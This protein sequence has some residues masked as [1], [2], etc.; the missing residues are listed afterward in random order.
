MALTGV[1]T[2]A[3]RSAAAVDGTA[4]LLAAART[5]LPLRLHLAP[6]AAGTGD[7]STA[8]F[9]NG[10]NADSPAS[11]GSTATTVGCQRR[12]RAVPLPLRLH[13]AAAAAAAGIGK[14]R[15]ATMPL[16]CKKEGMAFDSPVSSLHDTVVP[17]E[18]V[19]DPS[20]PPLGF[21]G[22]LRLF[23]KKH[24]LNS[25]VLSI[26]IFVGFLAFKQDKKATVVVTVCDK[27]HKVYNILIKITPIALDLIWTFCGCSVFFRG[28]SQQIRS[29]GLAEARGAMASLVSISSSGAGAAALVCT[30]PRPRFSTPPAHA[31]LIHPPCSART[32]PLRLPGTAVAARTAAAA[33]RRLS[34]TA[35]HAASGTSQGAAAADEV[36]PPWGPSKEEL[37]EFYAT[38]FSKAAVRQRF[39]AESR[40]AAATLRG[41]I[42]GVF[43][44]LVDNFGDMRR[45]KYAHDT[46]E[47]HLGMPF[48]ALMACIAV[49]QLWKASP[50]LCLDVALACAF[51]QLSVI[52][53]DVRRR[54]FSADL[55]IRLK[56][57]ILF[58]ITFRDFRNM[59]SPLDYIRFPMFYI[60]VLSFMWDLS[61]MKKYAKYALPALM[62]DLPAWIPKLTYIYRYV[63]ETET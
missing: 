19:S 13:L 63:L 37:A 31:R 26:S 23:L 34:L 49:Y 35:R 11:A 3:L 21:L 6:A 28:S 50:W 45:F 48:G 41:A 53:A 20:P 7:S 55:I 38:D 36:M 10:R 12:I 43:R 44:P 52:A 2:G 58:F 5:P 61:G 42:A 14:G 24:L 4:A 17:V 18:A 32:R 46:E 54:G 22:R 8:R 33:P 40:E 1:R 39:V 25:S 57:V 30:P 29:T 56:L 47:Y 60:Y 59:I 16:C 51:Y 62:D 9:P 27:A 15:T